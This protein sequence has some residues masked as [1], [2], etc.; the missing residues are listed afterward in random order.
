MRDA[1]FSGG[2]RNLSRVLSLMS[3]VPVNSG[4]PPIAADGALSFGIISP[5][6]RP[7]SA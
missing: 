2:A 7:G 4:T 5:S 1:I 3:A 6:K